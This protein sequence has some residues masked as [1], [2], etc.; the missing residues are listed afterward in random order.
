MPKKPHHNDIICGLE[1]L[2]PGS[3]GT[4][5][6]LVEFCTLF[7]SSTGLWPLQTQWVPILQMRKLRLRDAIWLAQDEASKSCMLR[8]NLGLSLP[9]QSPPKQGPLLQVCPVEIMY[10]GYL[11]PGILSLP[12]VT[13]P[14]TS[15]QQSRNS[16]SVTTD[17]P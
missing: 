11:E 13:L 16:I 15:P 14:R 4:W 3:L 12:T 7:T 8:P 1:V 6:V 5:L 9:V 10:P 17:E 2:L